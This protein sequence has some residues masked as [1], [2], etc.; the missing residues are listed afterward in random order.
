MRSSGSDSPGWYEVGRQFALWIVLSSLGCAPAS[1]LGKVAE[2]PSS[3]L[4]F[5]NKLAAGPEGR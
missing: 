1:T 4:E 3:R 2:G 5:S